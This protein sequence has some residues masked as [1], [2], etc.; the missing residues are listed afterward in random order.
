MSQI[1]YD[2]DRHEIHLNTGG[3]FDGVYPFYCGEKLDDT[4]IAL[5]EMKYFDKSLTETYEDVIKCVGH[6]IPVLYL[7]PDMLTR[8]QED[9]NSQ[10]A[11]AYEDLKLNMERLAQGE[12]TYIILPSESG[13]KLEFIK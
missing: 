9:P 7:P 10:E 3:D 1:I 11:M 2:P 5:I 13:Y 12:T 6:G 8:I 4:A